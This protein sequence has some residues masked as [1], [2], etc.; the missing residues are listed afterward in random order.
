LPADDNP[1]ALAYHFGHHLQHEILT[2]QPLGRP[3]E[4]LVPWEYRF[5]PRLR[6]SGPLPSHVEETVESMRREHLARV[7]EYVERIQSMHRRVNEM[8]GERGISRAEAGEA[9]RAGLLDFS[10]VHDFLR[11]A[12]DP[13]GIEFLPPV[14]SLGANSAIVVHFQVTHATALQRALDHGG[15]YEKE[16]NVARLVPSLARE[17][18]DADYLM[19]GVLESGLATHEKRLRRIYRWLRPEGVLWPP[20]AKSATTLPDEC[21]LDVAD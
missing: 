3:C 10:T 15:E 9:I 5:N 16:R 4:N 18:L 12:R 14:E 1:I 11:D 17:L 7:P 6:D 2:G 8:M 21:R 13:E 20:P 19:L